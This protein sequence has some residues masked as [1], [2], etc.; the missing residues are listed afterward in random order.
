MVS[1]IVFDSF[2]LIFR[3]QTYRP[4]SGLLET[5]GHGGHGRTSNKG[6]VF[7]MVVSCC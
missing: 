5:T 6:W 7:S 4:H 1:V 2:K 3:A